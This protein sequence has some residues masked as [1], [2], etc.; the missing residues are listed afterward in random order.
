MK[1]IRLII[2][3]D[4]TDYNGWQIQDRKQRRK[5]GRVKTIQG[6]LEDALF[7]ILSARVRLI[8]S[9][10]TDSGVHALGHVA[11]FKSPSGLTPAQIQKALNSVL[12][13]DIA[14]KYAEEADKDF[15]AQYD[16]ASKTYRYLIRNSDY[17]SPF[18]KRYAYHFRQP[19][20]TR[21][22]KMGAAALIGRHDFKAFR[23]AVAGAQKNNS[24]RTIKRLDIKRKNGLIEI[25][26]EADGFLYNMARNIVGTLIEVGRGKFASGSVKRILKSKDRK[27]AGPTAPAKGLCLVH[28]KFSVI[29]FS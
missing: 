24:V 22:M 4:G 10:R 14:V 15:N 11:N 20:N 17:I 2:E 8:S 16:A 12:P 27:L 3:Y 21:L 28:V 19:L 7:N 9:S 23:S 25:E 18:I 5:G 26:I 29:K 6:V 1:N 13:E